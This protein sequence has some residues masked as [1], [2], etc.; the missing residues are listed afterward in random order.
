MR[1]DLP[2]YKEHSLQIPEIRIEGKGLSYR[3]YCE[4][5]SSFEFVVSSRMHTAFLST[6]SATPI[7]PMEPTSFSMTPLFRELGIGQKVVNTH[8]SESVQETIEGAKAL[9]RNRE[10]EVLQFTERLQELRPQIF[11]V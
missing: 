11:S 8:E 6:V 1:S 10:N 4:L 9:S 3:E 2:F 7:I 5:L